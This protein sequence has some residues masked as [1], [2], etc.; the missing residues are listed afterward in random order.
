MDNLET[1]KKAYENGDIDVVQ[2]VKDVR[3]IFVSDWND[4]RGTLGGA[5]NVVKTWK[6]PDVGTAC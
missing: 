6:T 3:N 4:A 1:I 2:A 5:L